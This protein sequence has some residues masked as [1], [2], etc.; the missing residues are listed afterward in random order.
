[1]TRLKAGGF[2]EVFALSHRMQADVLRG[3]MRFRDSGDLRA[4]PGILA[5]SML[6]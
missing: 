2:C 4:L 1:M 3:L 5:A 6:A